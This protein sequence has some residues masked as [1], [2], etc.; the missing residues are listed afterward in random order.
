MVTNFPFY[1]INARC[2]VGP[3]ERENTERIK[4]EFLGEGANRGTGILSLRYSLKIY[5]N[6]FSPGTFTAER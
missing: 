2:E 5:L 4:N 3:R 6:D 1:Y